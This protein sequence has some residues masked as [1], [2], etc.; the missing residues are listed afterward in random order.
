MNEVGASNRSLV[1]HPTPSPQRQEPDDV[2]L[3]AEQIELGM[4]LGVEPR[5]QSGTQ[6]SLNETFIIVSSD[7]WRKPLGTIYKIVN[8]IAGQIGEKFEA[9]KSAIESQLS[10]LKEDGALGGL[11]E[12]QTQ[13]IESLEKEMASLIG[14]E[15]TRVKLN[16]GPVRKA[17]EL[18]MKEI[19]PKMAA[20]FDSKEKLESIIEQKKE[21]APSA[22]IS[23][24]GRGWLDTCAPEL[25]ELEKMRLEFKKIQP[26]AKALIDKLASLDSVLKQVKQR[27]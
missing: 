27:L 10:K 3:G 8:S 24:F 22:R 19:E 15:T 14:A 2:E 26:D 25:Q 1:F 21:D 18:Q 9:T 23:P 5:V 4:E 20:L 7:Q 12:Q 13:K 6:S 17:I 16:Q 11:N